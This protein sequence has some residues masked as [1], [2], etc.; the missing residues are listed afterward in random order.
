MR[1]IAYCKCPESLI[2]KD[3]L[4]GLQTYHGFFTRRCEGARSEM[5]WM[6]L[7]TLFLSWKGIVLTQL[8]QEN[9][10]GISWILTSK[11]HGSPLSRTCRLE[12]A[13]ISSWP[14]RIG[15]SIG[16]L[17]H[18]TVLTL[19]SWCIYGDSANDRGQYDVEMYSVERSVAAMT[20]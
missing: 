13:I 3:C 2:G 17:H 16:Q 14:A 1:L 6:P 9:D 5:V 4:S 7:D 18:H 20:E 19:M 8:F 11:G 10:V 15:R 12:S